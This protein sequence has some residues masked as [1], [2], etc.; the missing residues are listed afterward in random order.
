M[1]IAS[2]RRLENGAGIFF[3]RQDLEQPRA[4][5]Q[6]VVEAVPALLEE[7]VPAHLPGERCAGLL[8]LLLDERVPG[9]PEDGLAAVLL[10]PGREVARALDVEDDAGAGLALQH[11][12]GEQH[13]LAVGVDDL[14]AL[15]HDAEA[16]AVAVEG[17]S[18]LAL[19]LAQGA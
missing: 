4:R 6:R 16:V 18:E 9:F 19:A 15:R 5:V 10:D 11:V 2:G 3:R 17:E 7:R 1:L 8:Q 13:Q 12:G 14:A